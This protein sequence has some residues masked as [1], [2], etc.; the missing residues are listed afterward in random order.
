[1]GNPDFGLVDEPKE[2]LAPFLRREVRDMHE[3]I[4]KTGVS[5][6]L[7]EHNFKMALSLA[8]RVYVIKKACCA[9]VGTAEELAAREDIREE[10]LSSLPISR[11]WKPSAAGRRSRR[12]ESPKQGERLE[13]VL[14]HRSPSQLSVQSPHGQEKILERVFKL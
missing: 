11:M 2:G 9:F 7:V 1:M 12:P 14:G 10:C 5:I 4:S 8:R 13:E 6:L 3:G